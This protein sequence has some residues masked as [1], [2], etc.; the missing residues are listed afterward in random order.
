MEK[1]ERRYGLP[2]AIATCVGIVIGSGIFFKTEAVLRVTRGNIITGITSLAIMGVML[3]FCSYAFSLLAQKYERVNGLVDYAEMTV[4][5]RYAYFVG[6]FLTFIY[7]PAITGCLAWVTSMY[8]CELL[9]FENPAA[10]PECLAIAGLIIAVEAYVNAL[11]PRLSG[12][13]QVSGTVIKLIPLSLMAVVG[14]IAGLGNGQLAENLARPAVPGAS[15]MGDLMAATVSIAFVYEGWILSTS[16]NSELKDAKKNMPKALI[17]SAIFIVAIYIAY[18]LGICG[19]ISVDDLMASSSTAAFI[20]TFGNFFGR[21]LNI[22]IFISCLCTTH[23][24]MI[25]NSRNIYSLAV[26]G[27]GPHYKV[28]AHV[29]PSTRMPINST[30]FGAMI[31]MVWLVYFFGANV[32]GSWFGVF[33][34]D[35][36]ELP[37]VNL[38]AFYIPI[39]FMMYKDKSLS[40]FNRFVAPTMSIISCIFLIAC[41]VYTHGIVKYRQAAAAGTFSCPVLFYLIVFAAVMIYCAVFY[42]GGKKK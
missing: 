3:F 34:F 33:A 17:V 22:F 29:D 13:L 4:G 16:I 38:Y 27:N 42:R 10:G 20:R 40:G 18:F 25:A 5:P 23:G 11:A 28:F 7:T 12:K 32:L 26:R 30:L 19:S 8:L 35:S 37:I 21:I 36:S 1:M 15:A 2:T 24:L 31:S 14:I 39:F 6:S 41:A 9:G